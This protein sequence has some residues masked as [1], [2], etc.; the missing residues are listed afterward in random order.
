MSHLVETNVVTGTCGIGTVTCGPSAAAD[1]LISQ[2]ARL[3]LYREFDK[4]CAR[5]EIAV[6]PL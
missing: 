5:I 2:I 4:A 3:H 6:N 1:R